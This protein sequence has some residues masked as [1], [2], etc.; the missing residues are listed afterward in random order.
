MPESV[1]R[2]LTGPGWHVRVN[3]SPQVLSLALPQRELQW[4]GR[5]DDVEPTCPKT[6][7]FTSASMLAVHAKWFDDGLYA[8][9]ELAA[10]TKKAELL[11]ALASASPTVAA[12]AHLG[13]ITA[14]SPTE[15]VRQ[16]VVAFLA[17]ERR[18][19]PLGFYTWNQELERI[20]RQDRLLQEELAPGE[21]S[22]IRDAMRR[23]PTLVA[24]Y[25]GYLKLVAGLTNAPAQGKPDLREP[26]GRWFFPSSRSHESD[27]VQRL[28]GSS[29]VP[30]GFSL[31]DEMLSRLRQG[32]LRLTPTD[33]SGWYDWQTW[34]LEGIACLEQM[35]EGARIK[36]ND[37]YRQQLD[38][39]FKAV[40]SLTRETHVKQLDLLE[41]GAAL[42][43]RN[44][45][46]VVTVAPDISVEPLRTYYERRA[47]AYE[48]ISD[49]LASA[50]PLG[51]MKRQ[52]A[53]G[54]SSRALDEELAEIAALFRGAAS[55]AGD[56]LGMERASGADVAVFRAWSESAKRSEDVRMM[57]PVFYDIERRQTK[58]WMV[59]GWC[60]RW[61]EVD[62]IRR[63]A[64]TVVQGEV[65]VRFDTQSR[66]IAYPVFAE[67]YVS[68]L[69]NRDEFRAHCDRH[70]SQSEILGAL[71]L[72]GSRRWRSRGGGA[73]A[74]GGTALTIEGAR[75]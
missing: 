72:E 25:D 20:F 12:A 74:R 44:P 35:P 13:R 60:T 57:V 71:T 52:G 1:T 47:Q 53:D 6:Y 2:D 67:A 73:D 38:E 50:L 17:D 36:L 49:V 41:A 55:V 64:V 33:D 70:R 23:D 8:A 21:A 48:F 61:V 3:L 18:S 19:K 9:V 30:E 65:T 24:R 54:P 22:A 56:E 16:I 59:I 43:A 14:G 46:V 31:A 34:A 63:P 5:E 45:K 7:G 29:P 37:R 15:A 69:L 4:R 27:L 62:F 28:Y 75:H 68:R 26:N 10:Q 32:T 40:L 39:L 11:A 58:V 42:G 51:R 66:C